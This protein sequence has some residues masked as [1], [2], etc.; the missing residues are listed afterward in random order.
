MNV[1]PRLLRFVS[2][3]TICCK[4]LVV[5]SHKE[6]WGPLDLLMSV[7]SVS[8]HGS[9]LYFRKPHITRA[10]PPGP[11]ILWVCLDQIFHTAAFAVHLSASGLHRPPFTFRTQLKVLKWH[12]GSFAF[13]PDSAFQHFLHNLSTDSSHA[14]FCGVP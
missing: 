6:G 7:E 4:H 2:F 13:C 9:L 1:Y 3:I 14:S 8:S 11:L 12:T 5:L 10:P